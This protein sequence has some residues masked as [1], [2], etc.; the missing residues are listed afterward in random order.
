M[1]SDEKSINCHS[2]ESF[3][4]DYTY[5][6]DDDSSG[7]DSEY[8][9]SLSKN[10]ALQDEGSSSARL[11]KTKSTPNIKKQNTRQLEAQAPLISI[12]E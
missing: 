8:N 6:Y 4:N 9:Y 2:E 12:H 3:E 10:V 1:Q 11:R 7:D 5:P